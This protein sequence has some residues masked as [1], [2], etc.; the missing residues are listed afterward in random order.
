MWC[1]IVIQTVIPSVCRSSCSGR[2][3][4]CLD[5][6]SSSPGLVEDA[7][8]PSQ[9]LC[10]PS[11]A[12]ITSRVDVDHWRYVSTHLNPAD[13]ISRGVMP[14]ALTENSLWW[15]GPR[16]L[17][18]SPAHW[19][20]RPDINRKQELPDIKSA[21]FISCPQPKEFGFFSFARLC[22]V[23]AWILRFIQQ[24]RK[25]T[26]Q[27]NPKYLTVG[28]LCAA[29]STLLSV[30]QQFTYA[31]EIQ[32]LQKQRALSSLH[33]LSGLASYLDSDGVM[34]VGGRLQK[35]NL[36]ISSTHPVILSVKSHITCLLVVMTHELALHAGPS[37]VMAILAESY[38]I[39]SLKRL[40]K[41]VSRQ[42]IF[43]QKAYARTSQQMM[44]LATARIRPARPFSIT[45]IDFA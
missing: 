18:L 24:V 20:R 40:L 44:E 25:K 28:E 23:T 14:A 9:G 15:S 2:S 4:I 22:R 32:C 7:S 6:F 12:E 36:S 27:P 21:V 17:A 43:C 5:R 13:L 39:P 26:N 41:K 8:Q 1:T 38:H 29:K 34:R 31:C 42:C 3:N 45:G 16:W 19:P 10:G 33:S 35:A 37:T 30:S 11:V